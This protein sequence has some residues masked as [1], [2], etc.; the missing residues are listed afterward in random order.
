M[1]YILVKIEVIKNQLT[2]KGFEFHETELFL[3]T[4]VSCCVKI[5]FHIN[6][7]EI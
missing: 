4:P 5:V 2:L 1:S 3:I 7:I 6:Y